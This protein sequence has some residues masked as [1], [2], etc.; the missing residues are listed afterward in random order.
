[1]THH[2]STHSYHILPTCTHRTYKRRTRSFSPYLIH[3]LSLT[4]ILIHSP[5]VYYDT[6][7]SSP[8]SIPFL[9]LT[10]RFHPLE[11]GSPSFIPSEKAQPSPSNLSRKGTTFT[12]LSL[13]QIDRIPLLFLNPFSTEKNTFRRRTTAFPSSLYPLFRLL[14]S[15]RQINILPLIPVVSLFSICFAFVPCSLQVR[16]AK[17]IASGFGFSLFLS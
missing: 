15:F 1:M 9:R 14:F 17:L 12:N 13:T 4:F 5:V 8:Y 16:S 7:I 2:A 6:R 10:L 3:P 11:L